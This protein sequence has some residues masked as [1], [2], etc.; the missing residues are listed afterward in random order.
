MVRH[1]RKPAARLRTLSVK[2]PEQVS[3]RIVRVARQ[4]HRTLSAVVRDAIEQY[5]GVAP[6]SF[7][8][9]AS[10]YQGCVDGGPG[11]L[12]TNPHHLEGLG[13]WRR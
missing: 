7:A 9:A 3:A 4:Q 8:A 5:A 1:T 12:A 10:R 2:V 13:A 6:G 11:D